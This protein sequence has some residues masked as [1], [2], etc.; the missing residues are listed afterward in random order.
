MKFYCLQENLNKGLIQVGRIA[1]TKSSLPILENVLLK[2]ESGRLKLVTTDLEAVII[3]WVGGKVEKEGSLTVPCRLFSEYISSLPNNKIELKSDSG[4]DL[5]VSVDEYEANIKGQTAEDFPIIPEIKDKVFTSINS[6]TL[7]DALAEVVY[8][9]AIDDSKPVLAG[10][11]FYFDKKN[12][13]LVATDSYRLAEKTISLK[14]NVAA[15]KIIIPA[16]TVSDLQKLLAEI[17]EDIDIKI[18]ESQALFHSKNTDLI[19]RLIEGNFPDYEKIIPEQYSTK[20]VLP[21]DNF[22]NVVKTASLFAREGGN[23]I[24][25]KLNPKGKLTVYAA[26]SQVGDNISQTEAEVLGTEGEISF[27]AKYLLDVL[28]SLKSPKVS[29]EIGGKLKPAVVRPEGKSDYL[30]IIMPL[31]V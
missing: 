20:A 29:I 2:T 14:N 23:S 27:N 6:K 5:A 1:T 28:T 30:H 31:S 19:A 18:G 7:S 15:K 3:Q 26:A 13:K 10:V 11:L 4:V 22:I 9:A 8:A 24:R 25:L 16:K 17:N 21:R 12:L